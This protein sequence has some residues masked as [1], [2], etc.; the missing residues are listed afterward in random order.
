MS[1][2]LGLVLI[3][4]CMDFSFDVFVDSKLNDQCVSPGLHGF[5]LFFVLLRGE[6]ERGV[7]LRLTKDTRDYAVTDD[8]G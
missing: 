1:N 5:I 3:V 8:D 4:C 6:E 2:N 7:I